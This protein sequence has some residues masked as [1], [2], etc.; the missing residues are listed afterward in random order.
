M[1]FLSPSRS[2]SLS[3]DL[4]LALNMQKKFQ[5]CVSHHIRKRIAVQ[6]RFDKN[7]YLVFGQLFGFDRGIRFW[8]VVGA[9]L[10]A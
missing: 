10:L 1:S 3:L 2:L 8:L 6:I 5:F 4:S 7:A 9:I